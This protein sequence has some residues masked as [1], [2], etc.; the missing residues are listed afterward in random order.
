MIKNL[1]NKV[2]FV[3][4]GANRSGGIRVTVEMANG[5][6]KKGYDVEIVCKLTSAFYKQKIKGFFQKVIFNYSITWLKYFK[7]NIVYYKNINNVSF[8]ENSIVIS[9]GFLSVRD[10]YNIKQNVIKLRYSHEIPNQYSEVW[11]LP[12][13]TI[14]VS[15]LLKPLVEKLTPQKILDVVPNGI[16]TDEYFIE[17]YDR[18]GIGTIYD[19]AEMK[20]P[21]DIKLILKKIN[22]KWPH[23]LRYVYLRKFSKKVYLR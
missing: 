23:I 19:F 8:V 5:L 22:I 11:K 18:N 20:S 1:A 2:Y 16:R 3:I 9:V 13:E 14:S 7:G 12:M 17:E 6:I 15:P 10:V 4:P 21:E